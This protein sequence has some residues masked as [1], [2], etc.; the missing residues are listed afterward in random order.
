[1]ISIVTLTKNYRSHEA[2]LR[3]PNDRFYGGQLEACGDRKVIDRLLGSSRLVKKDFPVVFH[4]LK[5]EEEQEGAS[6]S[7]FNKDEAIKIKD[8]IEALRSVDRRL[9]ISK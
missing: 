4:A 6:P 9:G 2:I 1:M 3:F 5:G 8:Y 7:Y